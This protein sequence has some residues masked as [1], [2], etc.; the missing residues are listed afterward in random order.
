MAKIHNRMPVILPET[1]HLLWLQS[2]EAD[3][4]ALSELLKPYPAEE[5][6]AYP[7]SKLVNSPANDVPAVIEPVS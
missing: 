2:G 6:V 7:V 5:M 1:A 4:K 3:P